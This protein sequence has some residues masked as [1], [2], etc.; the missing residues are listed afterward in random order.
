MPKTVV[1]I[2]KS[3]I[4]NLKNCRFGVLKNKENIEKELL[5]FANYNKVENNVFVVKLSNSFEA[6]GY[7]KC[8]R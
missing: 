5:K 6:L 8:N 4:E 2:N 7:L 3:E 1:K